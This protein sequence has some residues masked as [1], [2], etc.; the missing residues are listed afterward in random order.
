MI[1]YITKPNEKFNIHLLD[2]YMLNEDTMT[3]ISKSGY[4][5][6]T[7]F[8]TQKKEKNLAKYPTL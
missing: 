6:L 4:I 1:S 3:R 5:D 8:K 2:K 7:F